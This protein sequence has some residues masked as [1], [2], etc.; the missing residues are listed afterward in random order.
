MKIF[1][2]AVFS[3]AILSITVNAQSTPIQAVS[4]PVDDLATY[5][6]LAIRGTDPCDEDPDCPHN[7]TN[8]CDLD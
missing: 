5:D 4:I 2:A 7:D 8:P 3:A 6:E 1:S